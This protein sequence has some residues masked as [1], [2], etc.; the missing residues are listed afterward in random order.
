MG[1]LWLAGPRMWNWAA[2]TDLWIWTGLVCA[3]VLGWWAFFWSRGGVGHG[4]P[5]TYGWEKSRKAKGHR[6]QS[7][8]LASGWFII[9]LGDVTLLGQNREEVKGHTV[10]VAVYKRLHIKPFFCFGD[11][12]GLTNEPLVLWGHLSSGT[13][14]CCISHKET[15]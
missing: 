9:P 15:N 13:H 5:Q 14:L 6:G 2:Q 11:T 10:S 3:V 1:F 12:E 4:G 7:N 8:L